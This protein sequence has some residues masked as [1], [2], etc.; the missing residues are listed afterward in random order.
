MNSLELLDHIRSGP[1][2]LVLDK[3][4]RF[5]PRSNL[6]FDFN[7]F[8]QALQSSETLQNITCYSQ[9]TLGITENEWVLLV[10]T[11]GRINDIQI[12][13]FYCTHGSRAFQPFQAVADAVNDARSLRE[14][15]VLL[16][17]E[18][19]PEDSSGLTAF[20]DAVREHTV[21]QKFKW[22][23]LINRLEP[24]FDLLLRALPTCPH[25]RKVSITTICA[26]T[27]AIKTLL[28]LPNTTKLTLN[29][30]I[31]EHQL[32][33]ADEIGQG[34]CNIKHLSLLMFQK[35]SS[36][37]TEAIKAIASAIR[38]NRNL[39]SL[40]LHQ[41]NNDLTDEAGVAFAEALTVNRTLREIILSGHKNT[42]STRAYDAFSAMLRVN[43]SLI[44][45]LPPFRGGN[46]RIVDSRN[47]VR[48]EQ[49][50]NHVGRGRLLSSSQTPREEWVDALTELNSSNVDES[51]DFNVSCLYSLL[52]LNP[53]TCM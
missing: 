31:K 27:D 23:D 7:E 16:G 45:E 3:P 22:F 17:S 42:L 8:L 9:Q 51:P 11:I 12:L 14:V 30:T 53:A 26:S 20:A 41:V 18:N 36:E 19:F 13:Q 10:H 39:E 5:P 2:K 52:R 49:R 44:L 37:T 15:R 29:L 4:L 34:H 48:I 1:A 43:T 38:L 32:A 21:L 6:L 46:D 25:L 24:S 33:V 50:L 35:P 47:Q 40:V 28:Q